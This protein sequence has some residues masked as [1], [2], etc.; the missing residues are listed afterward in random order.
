MKASYAANYTFHQLIL[1]EHI[2]RHLMTDIILGH[3]FVYISEFGCCKISQSSKFTESLIWIHAQRH[4][5]LPE[6]AWSIFN[7]SIACYSRDCESC[8]CNQYDQCEIYDQTRH[9]SLHGVG[10]ETFPSGL[11]HT[12][13]LPWH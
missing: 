11:S 3:S 2:Y 4:S 6:F 12:F 7:A 9:L 8:L 1:D 10:K 13:P 5:R